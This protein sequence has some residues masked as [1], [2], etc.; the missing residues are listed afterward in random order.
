MKKS[1]EFFSKFVFLTG[2]SGL[3]MINAGK[4]LGLWIYFF[5]KFNWK[6]Y[7]DGP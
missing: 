4:W 6:K 7:K 2:N 5:L 1:I 3:M